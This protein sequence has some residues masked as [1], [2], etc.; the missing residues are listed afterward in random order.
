MIN[1]EVENQLLERNQI[2]QCFDH[3]CN[4]TGKRDHHAGRTD[5]PLQV[6]R[7]PFLL[8]DGLLLRERAAAHVR[9]RR[10]LWQ[11]QH[12][13]EEGVWEE[14]AD[15]AL[16]HGDDGRGWDLRPRHPSWTRPWGL[17]SSLQNEPNVE[18][19]IEQVV[20][21]RVTVR[22][23]EDLPLGEQTVAHVQAKLQVH[24]F[25]QISTFHHSACRSS[26]Y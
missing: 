2:L 18:K 14:G 22:S 6:Q 5:N 4:R 12:D 7:R 8:C 25:C 21:S 16:G 23:Y 19:I 3:L 9:P 17:F 1:A 24:Y 26:L 15:G 11:P 20:V 10:P 13:P